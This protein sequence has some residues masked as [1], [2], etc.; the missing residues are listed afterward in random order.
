MDDNKISESIFNI[1]NSLFSKLFFSVDN[2]IYGI[3]DKITFIDKSI[4]EGENFKRIL[5]D[6]SSNGVLLIC[7]SLVFGVILF[8]AINYLFSHLTFSKSQTPSQFFFKL[9]I[10]VILMNSS[11]FL[12]SEIINLV[13]ILSGMI[14]ELG[15]Y[16]FN[17]DIS[18]SNFV[19]LI[20]KE[21]Y[22]SGTEFNIFSFEGIAKS[23]TSVGFMNLVFTYALRY[24]LVQILVIISPFAILSLTLD[25]LEWFFRSWIKILMS[26]LLEQ[27]LVSIILLLAFSIDIPNNPNL[28]QL[29]Y[30]GIIYALIRA[31]GYMRQFFGGLS[32]TVST[33]ISSFAKN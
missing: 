24:I 16:L 23:F 1:I 28:K 30:I 6:S 15:K 9:V 17:Q 22:V 32:T 5:G 31:N 8:F 3:L 4:L 21:I 13:S 12:C 11:I 25:K 7:N 33:N 2:S 14:I 20:N 26:L 29:L 18:F 10:Y 19:T 27:I